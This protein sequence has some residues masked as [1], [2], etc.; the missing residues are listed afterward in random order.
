[1]FEQSFENRVAGQDV[2]MPR[3]AGMRESGVRMAMLKKPGTA[4]LT[5]K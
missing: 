1:L 3:S 4:F 2:S 5:D